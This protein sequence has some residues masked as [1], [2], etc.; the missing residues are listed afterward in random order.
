MHQSDDEE[1]R[2]IQAE[3][4][5]VQRAAEAVAA[6][7][8]ALT[9]Q[10]AVIRKRTRVDI[11][12]DEMVTESSTRTLRLSAG[13]SD[14]VYLK[15][16]RT[17]RPA[18]EAVQETETEQKEREES[19]KWNAFREANRDIVDPIYL[20]L[21]PVELQMYFNNYVNALRARLTFG[22]EETESGLTRV[23]TEPLSEVEDIR[24]IVTQATSMMR[25]GYKI[26]V[27]FIV[28][29]V[30]VLFVIYR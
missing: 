9:R 22:Y 17:R 1:E 5:A 6:R 29:F 21:V 4:E 28:L 27:H 23:T 20:G 25:T 18:V 26:Q 11:M 14:R 3:E 12:R 13:R 10:R 16:R 19:I 30:F 15:A 8:R 24:R 7:R 2:S